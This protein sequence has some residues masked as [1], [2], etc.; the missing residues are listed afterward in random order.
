MVLVIFIPAGKN[1]GMPVVAGLIALVCAAVGWHY[2]FFSR[3]AGRLGEVEGQ[4][5]N[6]RRGIL[7]R[8]NGAAL[9]L[10]AA[11]F[12]AGFVSVDPGVHPTIFSVIW[13]AVMIL[14][15]LVVTLAA[16][17]MRYTARLRRRNLP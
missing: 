13:I 17:D 9:F 14:L 1:K 8:I 5:A 10:L 6:L 2:L 7:R 4:T 11:C 12:Y 15:L 3:A 16:V